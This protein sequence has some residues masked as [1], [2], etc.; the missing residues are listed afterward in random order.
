MLRV[1]IAGFFLV[2]VVVMGMLLLKSRH[3][4]ITKNAPGTTRKT[5]DSIWQAP[6]ITSDRTLSD[7]EKKLILY[8]SDLVAHTSKYFG[9]KGILA[10]QT[11]G[12]NCQNCHLEAGTKLWANNFSAVYS[13]YPKY[14]ER[15]GKVES[16]FRRVNDCFERSLN[17][18]PIDSNSHEFKA[19]FAYIK[20]LG[21]NVA[22]GSR[23]AGA[24]IEKLTFL[25][26]AA[27]TAKGRLVFESTCTSCHQKNGSGLINSDSTGYTYPPLWGDH[28]FADGAGLYRISNFA[29][30]IRGN[31]PFGQASH[32]KPVLTV[33]Q[34]WDV[35]AYVI[36]KPRP[37]FS[38][39]HDWPDISAKPFD[40][41]FGPYADQFDETRHKYGPFAPIVAAKESINTISKRR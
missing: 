13:T 14:R 41:P 36:S 19:I 38:R 24:G 10:K 8:G 4:A 9:P 1:S 27:D 7:D 16:I 28:S 5:S 26:R 12:M 39:R 18:K 34:A 30:F 32:A 11:N 40:F 2:S 25:Q 17:G 23:P 20:W 15:S 21:K 35:A 22:K 31:M 29:G 37:K 6:N 33:E 3:P